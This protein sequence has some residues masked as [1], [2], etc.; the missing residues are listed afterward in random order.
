[1]SCNDILSECAVCGTINKLEVH[2][3]FPTR[4]FGS[5][6]QVALCSQHHFMVETE[7]IKRERNKS[8][9][10]C[11]QLPQQEYFFIVVEIIVKY[12]SNN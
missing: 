4:F 12:K 2:T 5:G 6:M 11:H 9:D 1:M 3:V 8:P 7:I 10:R